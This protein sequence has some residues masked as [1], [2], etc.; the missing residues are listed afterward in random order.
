MAAGGAYAYVSGPEKP[1]DI[2]KNL[3]KDGWLDIGNNPTAKMKE[4][5]QIKTS[6]EKKSI[7]DELLIMH[8]GDTKKNL[9]KTHLDE[10]LGKYTIVTE[11]D[12]R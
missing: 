9:P 1:E 11:S 5:F 8:L 7:L 10:K 12:F 4:E 6:E 3:H 2:M